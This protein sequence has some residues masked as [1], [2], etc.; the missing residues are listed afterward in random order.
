MWK[1]RFK[2]ET[3]NTNPNSTRTVNTSRS[4]YH[5]HRRRHRRR[6]WIEHTQTVCAS[7]R[8][9]LR[10]GGRTLLPLIRFSVSKVVTS[11]SSSSFFSLLSHRVCA[12]QNCAVPIWPDRHF[13]CCFSISTH[14]FTCGC[15]FFA[16]TKHTHTR[17]RSSTFWVLDDPAAD[18][19]T[20]F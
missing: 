12:R 18:N 9:E 13:C 6:R 2:I 17:K 7:L 8:Q 5:S 10:R 19:R 16:Y 4:K 20:Q 11:S 14:L 15:V 1:Q 3:E